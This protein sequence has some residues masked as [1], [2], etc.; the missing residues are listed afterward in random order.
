MTE[1]NH[2]KYFLFFFSKSEWEAVYPEKVVYKNSV[3]KYRL[4]ANWT[5]IIR[6]KVWKYRK[7]PCGYSF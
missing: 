4:K 5:D 1:A 3:E 6:N 7:L 2:L